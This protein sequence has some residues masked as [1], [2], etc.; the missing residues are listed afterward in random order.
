[1]RLINRPL[2]VNESMSVQVVKAL[3]VVAGFGNNDLSPK[4]S[5]CYLYTT[6]S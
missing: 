6:K 1:M 2:S 5:F 3:N 4:S